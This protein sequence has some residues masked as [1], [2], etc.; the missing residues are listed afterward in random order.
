MCTGAA[1]GRPN[2]NHQ[3]ILGSPLMEKGAVYNRKDLK[4]LS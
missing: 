3:K 2:G 1:S 4:R